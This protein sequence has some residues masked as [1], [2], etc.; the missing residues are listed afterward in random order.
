LFARIFVT[1]A[2]GGVRTQHGLSDSGNR[3]SR[4]LAKFLLRGAPLNGTG[5]L[6]KNTE[7]PVTRKITVP[8]RHEA[9]SLDRANRP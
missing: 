2:S 8:E 3:F 7:S 4:H 5:Y 1:S 6:S 9:D